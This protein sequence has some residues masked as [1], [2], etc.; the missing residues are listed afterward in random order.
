MRTVAA[1]FDEFSAAF[2]FPYYF[3]ENWAAFDECLADLSWLP[4]KAYLLCITQSDQVLVDDDAAFATLI[5]IL[6]GI[7]AGCAGPDPNL[8][9]MGRQPTPFHVLLQLPKHSKGKVLARLFSAGV[10]VQT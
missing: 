5:R 2:Q 4:A 7:A 10:D 3:G 1:L 9:T 6:K 8:A